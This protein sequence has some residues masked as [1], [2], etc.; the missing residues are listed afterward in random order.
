[1]KRILLWATVMLVAAVVVA[2]ATIQPKD[3]A[4]PA[5]SK[6]KPVPTEQKAK[7]SPYQKVFTPTPRRVQMA[8]SNRTCDGP[9]FC[10]IPFENVKCTFP[11][12]SCLE[13]P[14]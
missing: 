14:C 12:G 6:G 10:G 7:L 11:G 1:M 9:E 2:S 5:E 3:K 8:C 13:A 4:S